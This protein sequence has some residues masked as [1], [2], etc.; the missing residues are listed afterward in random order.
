[1]FLFDGSSVTSLYRDYNATEEVFW[2]TIV[3]ST[4]REDVWTPGAYSFILQP[5]L[6][7]EGIAGLTD[8]GLQGF[9]R[10]N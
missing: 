10:R 4:S 9:M 7:Q 3:A 2:R 1:M 6:W 5:K 8:L